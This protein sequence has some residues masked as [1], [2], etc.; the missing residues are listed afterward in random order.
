MAAT[1]SNYYYCALPLANAAATE[2]MV[3][4]NNF[5][6]DQHYNEHAEAAAVVS[7]LVYGYGYGGAAVGHIDLLFETIVGTKEA[8]GD[9]LL[10]FAR[11]EVED[12]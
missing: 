10:L 12:S 1:A 5:V 7:L 11:V 8:A 3:E 2:M 6:K 4:D 9:L